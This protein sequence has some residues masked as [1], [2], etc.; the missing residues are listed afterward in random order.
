MKNIGFVLTTIA[1]TGLVAT[2]AISSVATSVYIHNNYVAPISY[3]VDAPPEQ[4]I[5]TLEGVATWLEENSLTNGNTCV[6]IKT[7]PRCKLNT[8]YKDMVVASIAEL[9]A[10]E[11][12]N[13]P[14]AVSNLSLK[15]NER[16]T[17]RT[18]D[19]SAV[20]QPINFNLYLRWGSSLALGWWFDVACWVAAATLLLVFYLW[21][22]S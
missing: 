20:I 5:T 14:V 12:S 13:D 10:A 9:K 19:G 11:A 17:R 22:E 16:F 1:V 2:N 8:F 3:A 21:L 7:N 18:K 15:L 6:F 4:A